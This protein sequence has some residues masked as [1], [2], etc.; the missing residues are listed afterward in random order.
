MIAQENL[1]SI[2]W[3]D[4]SVEQLTE[5]LKTDLATG[6][7]ST[8]VQQRQEQFGANELKNKPMISKPNSFFWVYKE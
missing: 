8:E 7:S 2:Q 1:E 3:H 5:Q 6:L 4:R